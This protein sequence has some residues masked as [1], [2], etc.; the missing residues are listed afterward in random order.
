MNAYVRDCRLM[1][2][3]RY[4]RVKRF[5]AFWL[6]RDKT[7]DVTYEE[8]P[9]LQDFVDRIQD[10]DIIR[11]EINGYADDIGED[12]YN[13]E[14]SEKRAKKIALFLMERGIPVSRI[15]MKGYGEIRDDRPNSQNRRVELKIFTREWRL[16]VF[17]IGYWEATLT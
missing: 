15:S 10:K 9:K 3:K 5:L 1:R 4:E 16:V 8:I 17:S 7:N 13:L 14:L 2:V 12:Q 11:V 6:K